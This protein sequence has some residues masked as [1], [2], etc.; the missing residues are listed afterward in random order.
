MT[1]GRLN[2]WGFEDRSAHVLRRP[3][4]ADIPSYYSRSPSSGFWVL[5][6]GERF[7]GII[8]V[9]ASLDADSDDAVAD[10]AVAPLNKT[11][12]SSKFSKA[13]AAAAASAVAA[14]PKGTAKTATIRHFYVEEQYRPAGMADELLAFALRHA[15]SKDLRVEAVRA[16]ASPLAGY[17][18]DALKRHGFELERKTERVGALR[19]QDSVQILS[20]ERWAAVEAKL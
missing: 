9:D 12:K 18:S 6:Y 7:I 19:W 3:D 11:S 10:K 20:R 17:A 14:L 15:F 2:R 5:Q 8:A 1:I 13:P 4:M 16:H